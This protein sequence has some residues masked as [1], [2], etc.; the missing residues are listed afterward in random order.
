MAAQLEFVEPEEL[1]P[2]EFRA[3]LERRIRR[4]FRMSVDEFAAAV[5]AGD[6]DDDIGATEYAILVGAHPGEE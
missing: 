2:D 3:L 1:N 5:R 4:R 6:F